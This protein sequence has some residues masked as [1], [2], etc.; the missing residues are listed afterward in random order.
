MAPVQPDRFLA[1]DADP[2]QVLAGLAVVLVAVA[3]GVLVTG[4]LDW[5]LSDSAAVRETIAQFGV[6][7]PAAFVLVQAAQVVVAPVPGHVLSFAAG[8]LFG[9]LWGYVYSM[10]GAGIG[11]YVA[12]RLARRYGRPWVEGVVAA[13]V[14]D[15]FD[16]VLDRYGLVGV[17]LVFLLPGFPDDVI[18]FVAGVSEL[19][20]RTVLAVSVLGR[21][22][23]YAVLVLS[24]AGLAEGRHLQVAVLLG[25]TGLVA[26]LLLW[27]RR[28]LLAW[29][30]E[31]TG[32]AK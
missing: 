10:V 26:T 25:A 22:P 6:F 23:G 19:D 24:G 3:A 20:L 4:Q 8:Y 14:L 31:H 29:L 5:L 28:Q 27:R 13:D 11:T 12:M 9:P 1:E 2:R 30:G 32:T 15:R 16:D 17:F 18:C 7:A 21:A